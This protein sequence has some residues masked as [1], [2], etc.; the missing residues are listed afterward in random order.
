[1][2]E[3]EYLTVDSF[4]KLLEEVEKGGNQGDSTMD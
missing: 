2:V 1:L 4:W 3:L